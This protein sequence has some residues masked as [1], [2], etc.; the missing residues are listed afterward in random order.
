[1]IGIGWALATPLLQMAMFTVVFTRVAPLDVGVPYPLYAYVGL[2]AWTLTAS[3]L[4]EAT[5]SLSSNAALVTKVR[6]PR[7]VL[8][9][10]SVCTALVDFVVAALLIGGLLWY[11]GI[12][13]TP[14]VLLFP[15]VLAVHLV[16]LAGL[17]LLLSAANLFW[18]DVRHL[19]EVLI[20]VWM[21]A[22]AVIYPL[23]RIGGR[24]GDFLTLNPMTHIVEAYRD[25]IVRGQGLRAPFAIVAVASLVLVV[26]AWRVFQR[27]ERRFAELA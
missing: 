5:N 19:F 9:L 13:V 10:A 17:A 3:S 14:T 18:R 27:S 25:V 15:V 21:F 23:Q 11:Y 1:V 26:I 8:P 16:L 22:T 24:L 6:F 7:A 20:N 4:R 12:G 2:V